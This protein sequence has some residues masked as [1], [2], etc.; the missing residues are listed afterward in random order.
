MLSYICWALIRILIIPIHLYQCNICVWYYTTMTHLRNESCFKWLVSTSS[1]CFFALKD[2][3]GM[4]KIIQTW[5]FWFYCTV[6]WQCSCM[7]NTCIKTN[8][9][10]QVHMWSIHVH[11]LWLYSHSTYHG[12]YLHVSHF[13]LENNHRP[14]RQHVQATG[15]N[16]ALNEATVHIVW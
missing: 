13:L 10:M 15:I 12:P 4:C 3:Y 2:R 11:R 14:M 7:H 5:F 9:A 16:P 8:L 1:T 6:I